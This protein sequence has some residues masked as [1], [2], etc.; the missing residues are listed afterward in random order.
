VFYLANILSRK[1]SEREFHDLA[2]LWRSDVIHSGCVKTWDPQ[3]KL[4]DLVKD[5][6]QSR[7]EMGWI[8]R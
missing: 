4:W 1:G 2:N 7:E 6:A 3:R 8:G 5:K